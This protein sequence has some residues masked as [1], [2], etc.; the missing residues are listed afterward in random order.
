MEKTKKYLICSLLTEIILI[1]V[2]N[3]FTRIEDSM[4][5]AYLWMSFLTTPYVTSFIFTI[6]YWLMKF[7]ISCILHVSQKYRYFLLPF[8]EYCEAQARVRQGSA[9]DGSSGDRPQSLNPC[10]ELTLKLVATH[11]PPT[12]T[13]NFT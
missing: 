11:H 3:K 10:Q 4:I 2:L 6:F 7:T 1:V 12:R 13:F 8:F 9:R 5:K